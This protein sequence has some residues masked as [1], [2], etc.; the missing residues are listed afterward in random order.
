MFQ[1]NKTRQ[2]FWKSDFSYPLI[3]TRTCT[4][5]GVKYA[6]FSESLACFVYLKYPFW[7]SPFCLFA[8]VK[9]KLC[10][11]YILNSEVVSIQRGLFVY[12]VLNIC[13]TNF[14]RSLRIS[15]KTGIFLKKIGKRHVNVG[16]IK[17]LVI[18][19]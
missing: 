10:I 6:R 3:R 19:K 1:E 7:N 16:K 13:D 11:A 12:Q 14:R 5:Q 9:K 4:Y 17:I 15:W 18:S 8:G 2:I